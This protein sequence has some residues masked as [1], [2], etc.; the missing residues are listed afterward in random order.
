MSRRARLTGLQQLL[1]YARDELEAVGLPGAAKLLAAA[2][3]SIESE[4]A[5]DGQHAKSK[6]RSMLQG[7]DKP[8]LVFDRGTPEK[9]GGG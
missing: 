2:A 7:L 8:R 5:A 3:I 6:A 1:D 9:I 4:I